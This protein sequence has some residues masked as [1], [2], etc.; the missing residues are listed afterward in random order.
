MA[1]YGSM[2]N[3]F[4]EQFRVFDYFC[5]KPRV[6]AS[7]APRVSLGK[8]KGILQY[9]KKGELREEG[10]TLADVNIP[11]LWTKSKLKLGDYFI[12]KGEEIYRITNNADWLFEGNFNCYVLEEV[13]GNTDT[14][15]QHE[16]VELGQNNYD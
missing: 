8:V 11:V 13:V 15:V 16:Y 14:Q 10:D 6:N 3:F 9:M 5:M 2:L 12:S 7:Y 4:T 1:I